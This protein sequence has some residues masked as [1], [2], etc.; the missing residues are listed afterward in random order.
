MAIFL[1]LAEDFGELALKGVE[2]FVEVSDGCLG[3]GRLVRE[4]GSGGRGAAR[5]DLALDLLE[6]AFEALDAL[7]WRRRRLALA[8]R[9]SACSGEH[10]RCRNKN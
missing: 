1:G 10:R 3:C 8:Q 5:K 7:L 2:P 9:R 6:L 4:S